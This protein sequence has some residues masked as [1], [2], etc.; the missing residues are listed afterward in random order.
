MSHPEK[1]MHWWD[2]DESSRFVSG[3]NQSENKSKFSGQMD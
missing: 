1:F 2:D 3:E